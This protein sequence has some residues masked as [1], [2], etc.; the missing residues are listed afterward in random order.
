M[1]FLPNSLIQLN[2]LC[3]ERSASITMS[4]DLSYVTTMIVIKGYA[5]TFS[6]PELTHDLINYANGLLKDYFEKLEKQESP[7]DG[8]TTKLSTRVPGTDF[9]IVINKLDIPQLKQPLSNVPTQ[10]DFGEVKS[11]EQPIPLIQPPEKVCK[12]CDGA[13]GWEAASSSTG[14][15]WRKCHDC[16]EDTSN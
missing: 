8:D 15:H 10:F 7:F 16:N 9:I 13:G 3:K 11:A 2:A 1:P 14:Y 12:T 5:I 6:F 4:F